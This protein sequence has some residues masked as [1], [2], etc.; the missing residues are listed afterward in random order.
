M[1]TSASHKNMQWE[2]VHAKHGHN[3]TDTLKK[4]KKIEK[5]PVKINT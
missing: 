3:Q 5:A 2:E 1:L 4:K